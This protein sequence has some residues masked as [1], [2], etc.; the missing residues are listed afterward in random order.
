MIRK[1]GSKYVL[2]SKDGKKKLGTFDSKK[3]A[4]KHERIVNYFKHAK[5]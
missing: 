1:E 4:K 5:K 2:H 3:A